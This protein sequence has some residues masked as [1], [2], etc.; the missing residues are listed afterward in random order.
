MKTN[1]LV[2][3]GRHDSKKLQAKSLPKLQ[4]CLSNFHIRVLSNLNTVTSSGSHAFDHA[5]TAEQ[6]GSLSIL[7]PQS[8][9]VRITSRLDD[10]KAVADR[11][12]KKISR[13]VSSAQICV[14]K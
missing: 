11:V 10:G 6:Q 13:L 2:P 5:K 1:W 4:I 9:T 7:A 12:Q 8:G 14:E 3:A